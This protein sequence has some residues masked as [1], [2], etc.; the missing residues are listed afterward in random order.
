MQFG[1]RKLG[2]LHFYVAFFCECGWVR[3]LLF[4]GSSCIRDEWF[5]TYLR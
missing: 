1:F 3:L 4:R 5:Y 2:D